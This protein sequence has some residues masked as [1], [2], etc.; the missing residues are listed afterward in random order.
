MPHC[1][2]C[3]QHLLSCLRKPTVIL[4]ITIWIYFDYM[5]IIKHCILF[6][7]VKLKIVVDFQYLGLVYQLV[8]K[9]G[10][11]KDAEEYQDDGKVAMNVYVGVDLLKEFEENIQNATSGQVE[12]RRG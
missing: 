10:T 3:F 1:S 5:L 2:P 6:L 11:E 7:Q 4:H 8:N 9:T 12:I